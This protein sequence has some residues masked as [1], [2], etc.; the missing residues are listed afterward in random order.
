MDVSM[1]LDEAELLDDSE[2]G[3]SCL[4]QACL[5]LEWDISKEHIEM[6]LLHARPLVISWD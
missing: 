5:Q 4:L 1:R 3:S 6:L 2:R